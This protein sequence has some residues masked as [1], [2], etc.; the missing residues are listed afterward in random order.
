MGRNITTSAR[1]RTAW[2]FGL[3]CVL[4]LAVAPAVEAATQIRIPGRGWGH[5]IGMSQY[6]ARG[7]AEHGYTA[8]QIV[9]YYY[10]GAEVG[11][12]PGDA[13]NVDVLL[14]AGRR[15]TT[16]QID[17]DG[18]AVTAGSST[19]Q[20]QQGDQVAVAVASSALTITRKRSATTTTL[21]SGVDGTVTI[22]GPDGTLQPLLT[23]ENGAY[24]HHYR[25]SLRI[26]RT[27]SSSQ[28]VNHVQLD[29]YLYGVVRSEMPTSWPAAALATQAICARSYAVATRKT[30]LFDLYSD[31]RSQMYLGIEHED[32]AATAAV[33]STPNKV[34]FAEGNV[35]AAFYS[36]T[37]G[38]RTAAI[39]DVWGS[40][41]K[42]WLKSVPDPYESSPYSKW[43]GEDIN[44]MSAKRF[45][46]ELGVSVG[47]VQR[48][49]LKTNKSKRVDEVIV[50]GSRGTD[51]VSGG[52]AQYRLGLRSSWFRVVQVSIALKGK[53]RP[54]A[55]RVTLNGLVLGPGGRTDLMVR[56]NGTWVKVARVK[57]GTGGVWKSKRRVKKTTVFALKRDGIMGPRVKVRV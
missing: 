36:S 7:F 45:S 47:T 38:G 4:V 30:G 23:A 15:S 19:F 20:L 39:E 44:V 13:S 22:T 35:V 16:I 3:L 6:G 27:G 32:A 55:R 14:D 10:S 48:V 42:S 5:G 21:A 49:R 52:T 11:N 43:T 46:K 8:E 28:L 24:G 12:A 51:S 18:A 17:G 34:V 41:P 56:S 31:T 33:D 1:V 40:A 37:T 26:T 57:V 2:A 9:K 25:G 29:K 50:E 53:Q 54:G